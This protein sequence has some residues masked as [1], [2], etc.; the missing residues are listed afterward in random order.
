MRTYEASRRPLER[1]QFTWVTLVLLVALTGA[2]YLGWI[3][4]PIYVTHYEVKQ[5]VRDFMNRAVKNRNDERLKMQLCQK[6]HEIE[7]FGPS[8]PAPGEPAIATEPA[9]VT[10]ERDTVSVPPMLH[11]AFEYTRQLTYPGLDRTDEVV[12]SVDFTQDIEVPRW[13]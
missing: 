11:V 8:L 7:A 10:W 2:G 6:L 9:D 13:K 5:V 4:V 1:G 3:W 12:V